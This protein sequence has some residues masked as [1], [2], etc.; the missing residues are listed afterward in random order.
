MALSFNPLDYPDAEIPRGTF[1]QLAGCAK[2]TAYRR[3]R[4]DP[5][6]PRPIVRG[7]R[8]FYKSADCKRYLDSGRPA[9][10]IA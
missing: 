6:W 4:N 5:A 9:N 1:C 8:V 7:N 3:E 10:L 2:I